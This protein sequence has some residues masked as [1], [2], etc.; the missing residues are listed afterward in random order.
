MGFPSVVGYR[1]SRVRRCFG[2]V[3]MI[4]VLLSWDSLSGGK[5][6]S[7]DSPQGIRIDNNIPRMIPTGLGAVVTLR[8]GC[9][10]SANRQTMPH[11]IAP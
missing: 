6:G 10:F 5:A 3:A 2:I 8:Q 11:K 4:A 1:T 9:L 7:A